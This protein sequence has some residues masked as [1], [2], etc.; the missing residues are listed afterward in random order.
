MGE[1]AVHVFRGDADPIVDDRDAYS[2]RRGGNAQDDEL[3]RL[4]R[5]VAGIL[6]VPH[7]IDENL[8]HLVLVDCNRR[9][10]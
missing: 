3:F 6:G 7:Q 4:A 5:L 10:P 8:Q 9:Y 1:Q 2:L